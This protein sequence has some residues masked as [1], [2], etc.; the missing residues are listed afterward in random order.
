MMHG[1]SEWHLGIGHWGAGHWFFSALTLLLVIL[2]V[3]ALVKYLFR[4]D[5]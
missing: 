1:D 3:A 4:N 5:K 2:L